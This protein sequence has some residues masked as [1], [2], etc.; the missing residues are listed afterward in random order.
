MSYFREI[1]TLDE[2]LVLGRE[3]LDDNDADAVLVGAYAFEMMEWRAII[4]IDCYGRPFQGRKRSKMYRVINGGA[5][6]AT[7]F[8]PG[9]NHG[10]M[11]ME[12]C[13]VNLTG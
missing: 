1:P 6:V 11:M 10:R 8:T 3:P 9:C 12:G 2:L 7:W 4:N 13:A 5:S